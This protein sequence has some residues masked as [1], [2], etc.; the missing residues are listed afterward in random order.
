MSQKSDGEA[1]SDDTYCE[2]AEQFFER[3]ART[4]MVRLCAEALGPHHLTPVEFLHSPFYQRQ[5]YGGGD[6]LNA[7][8]KTALA[9]SSGKELTPQERLKQLVRLADQVTESVR[10]NAAACPQIRFKAAEFPSVVADLRKRL[11][12]TRQRF[13]I[14]YL[15]GQHLDNS[16]SWITKI[17]KVAC[18]YSPDLDP[19][20]VECID[21]IL[22]EIL[23]TSAALTE[24]LGVEG[25]LQDTVPVLVG[26]HDAPGA[27][28]S[29]QT[30]Q[31]PRPALSDVVTQDG[32]LEHVRWLI[33]TGAFPLGRASIAAVIQRVVEGPRRFRKEEDE[34][35]LLALMD[36][37]QMFD[38]VSDTLL[39]TAV[40]AAFRKRVAWAVSETHLERLREVD[41]SPATRLEKLLFFRGLA[42]SEYQIGIVETEIE[43]A[44]RHKDLYDEVA[45]QGTT[46]VEKLV[47]FARLYRIIE[48][49]P[50]DAFR[51]LTILDHISDL[52]GRF[53]RD[54]DFFQSLT[55]IHQDVVERAMALIDLC[56]QRAFVQGTADRAARHVV[57]ETIAGKLFRTLYLKGSADDKEAAERMGYLKTKLETAGF[58]EE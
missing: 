51:K 10:E 49:T 55:W 3:P 45:N 44:F 24:L 39:E 29:G 21:E 42:E 19:Y 2:S 34:S 37:Y 30:K 53:I 50:L 36:V 13:A 11:A 31:A 7:F 22:S 9:Q 47:A 56:E 26:L 4:T 33:G 12:K 1:L 27:E 20:A 48:E 28:P 16:S 38:G 18:L 54:N 35:E 41:T 58:L 46:L 14:I 52:Q 17:H 32:T 43:R 15:L 23:L 6:L 25:G 40:V 8:Q 57:R 5:I